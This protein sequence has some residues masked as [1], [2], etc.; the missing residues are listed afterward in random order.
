MACGT[1]RGSGSRPD[2]GCRTGSLERS[3]ARFGDGMIL[4]AG[5]SADANGPDDLTVLLE[6]NAA[7][8][9][10]DLAVVRGV[11]TEE[12]AA[13]LRV[14]REVFGG[15]IEGA[16]GVGLLDRDVDRTDPRAV[17]AHVGDEIAARVSDGDVHGL[18]DLGGFFFG[19]GDDAARVGE[20]YGFNGCRH[21]FLLGAR[22]IK[23]AG[24][25]TT[26]SH[27]RNCERFYCGVRPRRGGA[28][29]SK[30]NCFRFP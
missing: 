11:D 27:E 19:G 12:L 26:G 10:H 20:V 13:G 1:V 8:E 3:R 23:A 6:W 5:P 29:N 18:A 17:H 25:N 28:I 4:L 16:R 7:C 30:A 24:L 21:A 9:D 2:R 15:D 22:G 14:R